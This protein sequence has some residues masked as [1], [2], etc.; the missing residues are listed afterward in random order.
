METKYKAIYNK[1]YNFGIKEEEKLKPNLEEFFKV[2]LEKTIGRYNLFDFIGKNYYIEIKSRKNKL[3]QYPTTIV[4]I[5][6][7]NKA[8]Q[9][10]KEGN[11][12]LFIFNFTDSIDFWEYKDED[13]IKDYDTRFISRNDRPGHKGSDYLEI[14]IN[15]LLNIGKK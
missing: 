15:D 11:R 1:D 10:V 5:N 2:N 14:P 6:K 13:S 8:K 12:I 4:G 3:T 9:L 7:I